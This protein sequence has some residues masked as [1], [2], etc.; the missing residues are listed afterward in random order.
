MMSG[1]LST[2][3]SIRNIRNIRMLL[4]PDSDPHH[5]TTQTSAVSQQK[6]SQLSLHSTHGK[7]TNSSRLSISADVKTQLTERKSSQTLA[8]SGES[9]SKLLSFVRMNACYSTLRP[10]SSKKKLSDE[11]TEESQKVVVVEEKKYEEIIKD[12]VAP[13]NVDIE[14]LPTPA[15]ENS[16]ELW[17]F[18]KKKKR[19]RFVDNSPDVFQQFGAKE[20]EQEKET[21]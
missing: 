15:Q 1:S 19:N 5:N 7:G 13:E 20:Q 4:V 18:A 3:W 10:E 16:P 11:E 8:T 21:F 2:Q 14:K 9:P 17:D 12:T 6:T